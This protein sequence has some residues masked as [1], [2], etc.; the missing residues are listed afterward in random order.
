[1]STTAHALHPDLPR[2]RALGVLS[3]ELHQVHFH[4][5]AD[6]ERPAV[7]VCVPLD[8]LT[9]HVGGAGDR[10]LFLGD[11]QQPAW[12]LYT[13]DFA[14]LDDP[15]LQTHPALLD[16]VRAVKRHRRR[17]P[18]AA[19][20]TVLGLVALLA[21]AWQAKVL[22]ADVVADQVP[23]AWE[24]QLGDLVYAQYVAQHPPLVDPALQ[25]ALDT[26]AA[27]L[28]SQLHDLRYPLHLHIVPD[29]QLNAFALPGGHVVL[30]SQ[31]VLEA[32]SAGEVLG[33]LGH[34]V[35][36]VTH[37]HSIR[38]IVNAV[39]GFALFQLILGDVSGVLAVLHDA[40]PQL[41]AQQFSRDQ[42]READDAGLDYLLAAGVDP[43]GLPK[44][45]ERIEQR[46]A[47]GP[48]AKVEEQLSFLSTH[49]Q[50]AER[51]AHLN[52]RIDQNGQRTYKPWTDEFAVLQRTLRVAMAHSQVAVDM[53]PGVTPAAAGTG[54]QAP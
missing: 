34:E 51:I 11:P 3:V 48:L 44:F 6:D 13:D 24:Q 45:F 26:L 38:A 19:V 21:G 14:L 22:V 35:A 1:M 27:P 10:L 8:R 15:V 46:A 18:L 5:P 2:G 36:H 4:A 30:N 37:R 43:H 32:A 39:G 42:E 23:A 7:D 28:L 54:T 41:L 17:G 16:A 12:S 50:T 33:V 25:H 31:V 20:V 9:L 53:P 49:P 29:S 40:G 47:T 52:A